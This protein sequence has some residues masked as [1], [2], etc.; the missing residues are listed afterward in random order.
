MSVWICRNRQLEQRKEIDLGFSP[1][2]NTLIEQ[3]NKNFDGITENITLTFL[4]DDIIWSEIR[5]DNTNIALVDLGIN[6]RSI[7]SIEDNPI[8]TDDVNG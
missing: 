1:T 2:L 8:I 7:I 3:I 4:S 6:H 5:E